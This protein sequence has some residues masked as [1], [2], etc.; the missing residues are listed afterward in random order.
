MLHANTGCTAGSGYDWTEEQVSELS[1]KY[2]W[3]SACPA[4]SAGETV[5]YKIRDFGH[6][7]PGSGGE[8]RSGIDASA[9]MWTFFGLDSRGNGSSTGH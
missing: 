3:P 4:G 8:T 1:F 5:F 2:T 6:V 9:L 7:W